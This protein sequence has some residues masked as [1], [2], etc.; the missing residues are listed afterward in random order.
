MMIF[1]H[2]GASP[3]FGQVPV[4]LDQHYVNQWISHDGPVP[5]PLRSLNLILLDLFSCGSYERDGLYNLCTD[6][7]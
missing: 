7:E 3:H 2:D 5:W 6:E 4:Y 1:Q